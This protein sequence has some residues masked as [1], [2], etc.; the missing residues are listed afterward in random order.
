MPKQ[1]VL[2]SSGHYGIIQKNTPIWPKS[3]NHTGSYNTLPSHTYRSFSHLPI[4]SSSPLPIFSTFSHFHI[5]TFPHFPIPS[6]SVR[7]QQNTSF[8]YSCAAGSKRN[9]T[10]LLRSLVKNKVY[11]GCIPTPQRKVLRTGKVKQ[12]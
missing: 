8:G 6:P 10:F 7:Y 5:S 12:E 3:S 9:L 2:T 1:K 4:D 11:I